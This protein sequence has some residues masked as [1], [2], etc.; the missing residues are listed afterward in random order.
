MHQVE[1][2]L[3][4]TRRW[5]NDK[6]ISEFCQKMDEVVLPSLPLPAGK[7]AGEE[8]KR[9]KRGRKK[10]V[11]RER[12]KKKDEMKRGSLKKGARSCVCGSG[13]NRITKRG[14]PKLKYLSRKEQR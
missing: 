14:E 12:D 8:V 3:P 6:I 4:P 9:I 7:A 13:E 10:G 11:G 2:L 5:C 1:L